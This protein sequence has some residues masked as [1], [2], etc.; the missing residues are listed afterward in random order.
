MSEHDRDVLLAAVDRNPEDVRSVFQLAH[1]YFS[2][3]DFL[4]ARTWYE[5]RIELGGDAEEVYYAKFRVAQ[6]MAELGEP[7]PDVQAAYLASWTFRPTRAEPL[8]RI[9]R[10]YR[11]NQR[12]AL[13]YAF[14]KRAAELPLPAEQVIHPQ[15]DIYSWCALDEQ[16]VCGSW[17]GRSVESFHLTRQL[18]A[19]NDIPEQDR[20]RMAANRDMFVPLMVA[21][22]TSHSADWASHL[23]G[24]GAGD[25]TVTI[26]VGADV[27]GVDLTIN[28]FLN[29]CLD[30]TR[31]DRVMLCHNGLSNSE[32]AA[33]RERYPFLEVLQLP[34]DEVRHQIRTRFW[35]RLGAGWQF[36]APE[37]LITRLTAILDT[38]PEVSCV[39]INYTDATDLTGTCAPDSAVRCTPDTGRYTLTDTTVHGPAMFDTTRPGQ[40]GL[41]RG[42]PRTATLDEVLCTVA[43]RKP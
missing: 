25:V 41:D 22:A 6:A 7:W 5:R 35:L 3:G 37:K 4:N 12:Y 29:C 31:I 24:L 36:F 34:L 9:A 32:E 42:S 40:T 8:Y 33:L 28:S 14:A 15:A 1:T 11:E 38:E 19:H 21:S 18:L 39:G 16:A 43:T 30:L 27:S 17:T 26:A 2:L 20:T 23:T 13:G 10:T